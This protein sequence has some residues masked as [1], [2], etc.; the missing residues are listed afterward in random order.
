MLILG[1]SARAPG[2]MQ[3]GSLNDSDGS[4]L[5]LRILRIRRLTISGRCGSDIS[6]QKRLPN[7]SVLPDVL[8]V[9]SQNGKISAFHSSI[10][11]EM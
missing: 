10:K 2:T 1:R 8:H 3:L 9:R 11:A 5:S 4:E 6:V 7:D